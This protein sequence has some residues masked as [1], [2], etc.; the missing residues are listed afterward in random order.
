MATGFDGVL[1]QLQAEERSLSNR[2]ERVRQA[3]SALSGLDGEAPE[4]GRRRVTRRSRKAPNPDAATNG[5]RKRRRMSAEARAKIGAAQRK[6]W[7]AQKATS[8][9]K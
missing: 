7:A 3:L 9:K 8:A 4:T 5:K 2:L 6:R 1:N